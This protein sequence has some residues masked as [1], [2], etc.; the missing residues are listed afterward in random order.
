MKQKK[1]VL[2]F[3]FLP[4]LSFIISCSTRTYDASRKSPSATRNPDAHLLHPQ[5]KVFHKDERSTCIYFKLYTG[6]LTYLTDKKTKKELATLRVRCLLRT[7]VEGRDI[8]DSLDRTLKIE[9]VDHQKEVV[10]R[11]IISH[12][13]RDFSYADIAMKDYASGR[14]CRHYVRIDNRKNGNGQYFLSMQASNGKPLFRTYLRNADTILVKNNYTSSRQLFVDRY[15]FDFPP[16]YP[17]YLEEG[18]ATETTLQRQENFTCEKRGDNFLF[19]AKMPGIYLAKTKPEEESGMLKVR[20]SGSFPLLVSAEE[21][22]EAT[23][24][25]L[26]SADYQRMKTSGNMKL[27]L[28]RFWLQAAQNNKDKAK[29]LLRVW[30]NRAVYANYFFTSYKE[31]WKTDKGMVYMLFGTPSEIRYGDDMQKWIYK[32][33]QDNKNLVFYFEQQKKSI[34][35]NDYVLLRSKKLKP[36]VEKCINS[37]KSGSI[38]YW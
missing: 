11:L 26:D 27:S 6:E 7:E 10:S 16:A 22:L 31:G 35:P 13:K 8:L 30:Y 15:T 38:Y 2:F 21:L 28:D 25:L 17:A 23:A 18:Q 37:W 14:E 1:R 36:I 33:K 20:F 3:L 19:T 12:L 4:F 9:K 34:A 29:N 5:F 24:Y 32:H